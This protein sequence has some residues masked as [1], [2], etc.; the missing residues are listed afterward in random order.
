MIF[1]A[2]VLSLAFF[3]VSILW[4]KTAVLYC[5]DGGDA[6]KKLGLFFLRK[7][8]ENLELY[9]PEYLTEST[10]ILRYRL[11]VKKGLVNKFSGRDLV[12]YSEDGGSLRLAVS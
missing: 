8:E 1:G 3:G 2:A 4:R 11:L 9:L 12:V 10:D 7:N 6:Y 5:Y